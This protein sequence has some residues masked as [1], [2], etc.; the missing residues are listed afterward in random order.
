MAGSESEKHS[1]LRRVLPARVWISNRKTGCRSADCS[2][3]DGTQPERRC[4]GNPAG[5]HCLRVE[6]GVLLAVEVAFVGEG[7][8]RFYK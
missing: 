7:R 1:C 4:L 6:E 5:T 2:S 8:V 3:Y